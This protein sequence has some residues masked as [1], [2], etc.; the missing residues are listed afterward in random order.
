MAL[1]ARQRDMSTAC[2]LSA[3]D[4]NMDAA[5]KCGCNVQH[6][7]CNRHR[8]TCNTRPYRERPVTLEAAVRRFPSSAR[9]RL[10]PFRRVLS[11]KAVAALDVEVLFD[12]VP[13]YRRK[14][15]ECSVGSLWAALCCAAEAVVGALPPGLQRQGV[16]LCPSCT[17]YAC[18]Q[19]PTAARHG[20]YPTYIHY[21][22]P[23]AHARPQHRAR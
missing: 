3:I 1:Q 13:Q 12:A 11:G 23:R 16:R 18:I 4:I 17:V 15:S 20:R 10:P 2:I 5:D 6:T 8:T 22:T 19:Y 21:T 7:R 9:L 14:Y